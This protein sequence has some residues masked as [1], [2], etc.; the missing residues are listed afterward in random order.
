MS[1]ILGS[2]AGA[3]A[4]HGDDVLE[5]FANRARESRFTLPVHVV[6][7][8]LVSAQSRHMVDTRLRTRYVLFKCEH[9]SVIQIFECDVRRPAVDIPRY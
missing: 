8:P 7:V 1:C 4:R 2:F 3:D 6:A 9:I 5:Y